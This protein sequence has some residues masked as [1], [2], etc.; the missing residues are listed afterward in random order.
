MLIAVTTALYSSTTHLPQFD[1]PLSFVVRWGGT[2]YFL[3]NGFAILLEQA[4]TKITRRQV[5]GPFGTLW[6]SFWVVGLGYLVWRSWCV[7]HASPGCSLLIADV[8]R[9]TL[10]LTDGMPD[11]SRWTWH[12]YVLPLT[13][14]MPPGLFTK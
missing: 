11:V 1:P 8:R 10:G 9:I 12:R 13:A 5:G 2:L 3:A 7:K 14:L 4:F 6:T